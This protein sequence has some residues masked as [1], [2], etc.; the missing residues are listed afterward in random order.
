MNK[1]REFKLLNCGT[2]T[3]F[4]TMFFFFFMKEKQSVF[5]E[6]VTITL[7][8]NLYRIRRANGL[9]DANCND[10]KQ[11]GPVPK[12]IAKQGR[13]NEKNESVLYVASHPGSLEREVRLKDG[14]E[15]Y[16]ATYICKNTFS[17]GSFLGTNNRVNTLL[18]K[19]AMSISGPEE[20]T[21]AENRLID[22][23]FEIVKEKDLNEMSLDMLSSFY[24]YK[25]VPNLYNTTNK[26]AKLVLKINNNG[27]RY[28]S[29]YVPIELSG[30]PVMLTLDG[31]E[32]GNYVLTPKGYENIELVGVE[33][34]IC[35]LD[36][37]LEQVIESFIK[38]EE[39]E[40]YSK[41]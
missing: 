40:M 29:V 21:E 30:T 31:V 24:I 37:G 8:T 36:N 39:K 35:S 13:F 3:E 20:L 33:R 26:L 5:T 19:I 11:W 22:N 25:F 17:V 4:L 23:Y 38:A 18:H 9:N 16:L 7:G 12:E 15:Y 1:D 6:K 27:I 2:I 10:P 34:K 32:Y 14:E 28:S 41:S